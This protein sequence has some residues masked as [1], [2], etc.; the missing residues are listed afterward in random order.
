MES[1]ELLS[2][3]LL[4]LM[5]VTF[6]VQ[7][8]YHLGI[9]GR[10][11]RHK[12]PV[13]SQEAQEL[14]VS[15]IIPLYEADHLFLEERLPLFLN[16][17]HKNYEVVIVNVTGDK[18]VN[19]QLLMMKIRHG[20][21]LSTTRLTAD[22]HRPILTKIALNVGIKAA[23]YDNLLF[24]LPDCAP[25]SDRWAEVMARGFVEHDVVLGYSALTAR[26]GVWNRLIRCSNMVVATRWIAAAA[27]GHPHRGML[28][29]IGFKK[30]L[31]FGARGFNY[32]NLNMGED[33]LFIQT[34]AR[35]S[36]TTAIMGGSATLDRMTWGGLEWWLP[37]RQKFTYPVRHYTPRAKWAVGTELTSRAL[38]FLS[39]VAVAAILPEICDFL[40]DMPEKI[41]RKSK[42]Y[43]HWLIFN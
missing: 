31:Y 15:V 3:I 40:T 34:I 24:T 4:A 38:F 23:R 17:T 28:S 16:Q 14:G 36:N 32:L 42:I 2:I 30:Q 18:E 6:V 9:Y 35:K 33:D 1:G 12:N 13:A 43:R 41:D 8:C 27:G 29:N 7:M 19:D 11:S 26:K 22:P 21:K 39:A 37:M 20:D 25:R 10:I 5:V